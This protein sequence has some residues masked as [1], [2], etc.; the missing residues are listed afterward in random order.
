MTA[1]LWSWRSD[2]AI[3]KLFENKFCSQIVKFAMVCMLNETAISG[4]KELRATNHSLVKCDVLKVGNEKVYLYNGDLMWTSQQRAVIFASF[5]AGGLVATLV[6]EVI[7]NRW[8]G[9]KRL[10]L[11][12]AIINVVG[13]FATPTVA[14]Y[15]GA[16]PLVMLRF[17]MGFGQGLLWPCMSVL[18]GHWFPPTEKST[19]LA[20]AT[21]GNQLSV[22]IAMF[23]TAEL[24]QIPFM[25]G[26]PMAFHTYGVLGVMLCVVWQVF[27][28]DDPAKAR[29]ITDEEL[30]IIT[31]ASGRRP[32]N[33]VQ[34]LT[35]PVVW[36][37]AGS[38]FAHNFIT[39]GTVTYLPL[40]YKTVLNMSL[41]SNGILSALPFICQFVSKII[42]AG[43]A[44]ESKKR[45]WM[46][47]TNVTKACNTSASLGLALCFGLLCFCDCTYRWTA[48]VL[49]CLAMAF[50]SGYVPGYNTSVVSIAPS[51]TAAIASF[52]RIW[53]QIASSIA[54]YE[55]GA[56][57]KQGILEEWRVVFLTIVIICITTGAFFQISGSADVQ[58]WDTIRDEEP[59][60]ELIEDKPQNNDSKPI[61]PAIA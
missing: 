50:V 57:T 47:F 28:A 6:T 42:Y 35:S 49:V 15:F 52:S 25:G 58:S 8:M 19:A 23:A 30:Q 59:K 7:L 29:G 17:I 4:V 11:Y 26:W 51:Q 24:C 37:I 38:A 54:P 21:T 33:W 48:V 39:V 14:S 40:Y 9:A 46:G 34:L 3:Q 60:Q 45:K 2:S 10:V 55:I 5:Y 56:L 13:T 1:S 43:F 16:V 53:A 27:V 31:S 61:N 32:P 41:T 12:G 20:I 44:D 18:V 22:V 36:S